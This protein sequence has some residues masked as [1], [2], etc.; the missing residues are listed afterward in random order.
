[1]SNSDQEN[2]PIPDEDLTEYTVKSSYSQYTKILLIDKNVEQYQKFVNGANSSTFTIVYKYTSKHKHLEE[3][4]VANLKHVT[5]LAIVSHGLPGEE[6]H[7]YHNIGFM[8]SEHFF[9]MSDLTSGATNFSPNVAFFKSLLT[10]MSINRMD[11]LACNLLR[12]TEWTQ[13]L[14]LLKS[15][16]SGLVVGASNDQT[17][18][19][20]YG[21]N[22]TM[23]NTL[24]NIKTVYFSSAIENYTGLLFLSYVT[25][26]DN[27]T[28]RTWGYDMGGYRIWNCSDHTG[29]VNVPYINNTYHLLHVFQNSTTLSNV[30]V[31]DD[32]KQYERCF[33]GCKTLTS[34]QIGAY[35]RELIET[36]MDTNITSI[37]IGAPHNALLRTGNSCC[38]NCTLLT[39]VTI[40]TNVTHMDVGSFGNCTLLTDI[41]IPT[42]VTQ[43]AGL[44]GSG[45]TSITIE[46]PSNIKIFGGL[47]STP[48]TSVTIPSSVTNVHP[49]SNMAITSLTIPSGVL[50][51]YGCHTCSLLTS[52]TIPS[53]VQTLNLG[54]RECSAL[55]S[56]TIPDSC[57][58]VGSSADF[59]FRNLESLTSLT[60]PSSLT[61]SFPIRMIG[62]GMGLTSVTIPYGVTQLAYQT[63]RNGEITGLVVPDTC[64]LG[65]GED[66]YLTNSLRV[67]TSNNIYYEY[68]GS[69]EMGYKIHQNYNAI[70]ATFDT[71][72][73]TNWSLLGEKIALP[74]PSGNV[75]EITT[76][77]SQDLTDENVT[78]TT[79]VSKRSYTKSLIKGL[80]SFN[81]SS[82]AGKAVT[83]K[84]ITLPGFPP[85]EEIVVFNSSTNESSNF[86]NTLN[87]ASI[88]GKNFYVLME[89][90][91]DSIT[92]P[93]M[94]SSVTVTK[95]GDTTFS[96]NNGI[97]VTTVN[98]GES[99]THDGLTI[100]LGSV[101]GY[102]VDPSTICFKEGTK[103]ACL[104]ENSNPTEIPVEELRS[105]MFVKTYKHGYIPVHT[106][107]TKKLYNPEND[108][109]EKDRLYE[110]TPEQY[111]DLTENLYITGC[112]SIL[113]DQLNEQQTTDTLREAQDIFI[114]DDKYRLMA[115]LDERA[116]PWTNEGT[117]SIYHIY[118]DHP[119]DLMNY[120]IYA[121]GLLVESCSKRSMEE[122]SYMTLSTIEDM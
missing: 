33:K 36:F 79:T 87:T 48:L 52:V 31:H 119:D 5:R 106:I 7:Y 23:E 24:E 66:L 98:A 28:S 113:V 27:G 35:A 96:V 53:S 51:F 81:G 57:T 75:L 92:I 73:T 69:I 80:F 39:S 26:D 2:V 78:G 29:I 76:L 94:A 118:L 15:F 67:Y 100:N 121:N 89:N 47:S 91:D 71:T 11:F 74:D 56:L 8:E 41:T 22:W 45:L 62:G 103:I 63:I 20:Q 61:S 46:E 54:F 122:K 30:I 18:N 9:K 116:Q 99:Y 111:P 42:S 65:A 58:L 44:D 43:L 12:Y 10:K 82:L 34:F 114:T 120:G 101:F 6:H 77:T 90:T 93:S 14:D 4:L 108:T 109:R 13:Y 107:G 86:T 84:N 64:T 70:M 25:I 102:L 37:H 117:Y 110:C 97:T 112:H 104:D 21:G 59:V 88:A 17:G 83:L 40:G 95:S 105:G 19:L 68:I 85:A 16:K 49:I 60:L 3:F 72:D 32:I 1:M 50:T 115:F 55:T 38:L